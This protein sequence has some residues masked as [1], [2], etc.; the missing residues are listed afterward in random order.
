MS[1]KPQTTAAV[2]NPSS[3]LS[4]KVAQLHG[5]YAKQAERN[6][7]GFLGGEPKETQRSY[8]DYLSGAPEHANNPET[9]NMMLGSGLAGGGAG[10]LLGAAMGK[11]KNR[12]RN[13]MLGGV[14]GAGLGT[15]AGYM[16]NRDNANAVLGRMGLGGKTASNDSRQKKSALDFGQMMGDAGN[17]AKDLYNKVP[18]GVRSGIGMGGIGG[19]LAGGLA[20]LVAPGEEYEYDDEGNVIGR[21]QRGRFGAALRGLLGG[22]LAGA[23]A[24]GAAGHF[25]PEMTGKAYGAATGFGGDL[26]RRLG[27]RGKSDTVASPTTSAPAQN[28]LPGDKPMKNPLYKGP[29]TANMQAPKSPT[30]TPTDEAG[31]AARR[32]QQAAAQAQQQERLQISMMGPKAYGKNQAQ[33]AIVAQQSGMD[34]EAGISNVSPEVLAMKKN[35]PAEFERMMNAAREKN[36]QQNVQQAPNRGFDMSKIDMTNMQVPG[37]ATMG[38]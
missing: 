27:F 23:A 1:N 2:T 34:Q 20:G 8:L 4:E 33:Q 22:G 25:A 29:N 38:R 9:M 10:A 3:P 16:S 19:G 13:T 32:A 31:I 5:L 37:S 7:A 26:A 30:Y 18:E 17:Y 35:N 6:W 36:I 11:K 21:K 14:A 15:L 28:T 24:G 12:N